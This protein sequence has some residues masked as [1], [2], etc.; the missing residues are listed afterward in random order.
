MNNEAYTRKFEMTVTTFGCCATL[1]E[2]LVDELATRSLHN[3]PA[4]RGGV[5]RQSLAESNALGHC[6]SVCQC[7]LVELTGQ[8]Q[9]S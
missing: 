5:V 1:F 7:K 6:R 9:Q 2:I 8:I 3:P 4:V